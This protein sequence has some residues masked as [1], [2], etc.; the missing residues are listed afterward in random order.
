MTERP[1]S[2]RAYRLLLHLAP[3]HLHRS[4]AAPLL[5]TLVLIAAGFGV[6]SVKIG[7]AAL[8]IAGG[9]ALASQPAIRRLIG[10]MVTPG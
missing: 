2:R 8:L 9:A 1:F 5:S 6:F 10:R 7:I 4:H 3:G